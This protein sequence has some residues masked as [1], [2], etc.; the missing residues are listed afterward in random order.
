MILITDGWLANAGDV[1][2][3]VATTRSLQEA[4][5]G[6][7]VAI[8]SHHRGLVGHLYP[9]L[10]L[11]PPL[12]S[13]AGVTWPWS[14]PADADRDA[15]ERLVDQ[16]DLVLAAGGGYLL[17]PYGPERRIRVYE[18]L[19]ER[20]KRMMFYAQ[21]IG[22][23]EDAGLRKRLQAVLAAAEL[24]LV[25]DEPS[26][27]VVRSQRPA[28][29]VHLTADEAFLFPRTRR[30]SR[31]RSLLAT[32]SLHPWLGSS[33][34]EE[35]PDST[36]RP[37]AAALTRLLASGAAQRITLASTAQG[38]GGPA[39]ALE[40][41][42]LAAQAV[43]AAV[44]AHWRVRIDLRS[45]YLRPDDY[46]ALAAQHTAAVSMRM[47][48]A[49]LAALAGTPVLLANASDKARSLARRTNGAIRGLADADE[50]SRVDELLAPLLEDPRQALHSQ[51]EGVE[52]MRSLARTNA[53]LVAKGMS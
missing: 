19:L 42:A 26:L 32:I 31:P 1:A 43:C 15:V 36:L 12:D 34:G 44:P 20:G 14:T 38:L 53:E 37:L 8:A 23:F 2:S 4:L 46:A 5:P 27:D 6:T 41:D 9:E 11:V 21:S 48:G 52:Q 16:A 17:E 39:H 10:D 13:L 22:S 30:L 51:D 49:I 50:L 18:E 24:I 3:Y 7:R 29:N 40:D 33:G 45:D 47:H 25:R 28:D 35:L